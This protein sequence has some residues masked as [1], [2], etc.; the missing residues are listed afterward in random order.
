MLASA[1]SGSIA[2]GQERGRGRVDP[3]SAFEAEQPHVGPARHRHRRD[4][5]RLQVSRW[6]RRCSRCAAARVASPSAGNG[7]LPSAIGMSTVGSTGTSVVAGAS[8]DDGS[9]ASGTAGGTVIAAASVA[10]GADGRCR[11]ATVQSSIACVPEA[12]EHAAINA[13]AASHS[14]RAL[15]RLMIGDST[16]V[17]GRCPGNRM[18]PRRQSLRSRRLRA[19]TTARPAHRRRRPCSMSSQRNSSH[20]VSTASTSAPVQAAYGSSAICDVGRADPAS[21]R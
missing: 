1:V 21:A 13:G 19:S 6:D 17:S 8:V 18:R 12:L 10:A 9:G 15:A 11:Y 14:E 20:S 7:L 5:P 3:D 4:Q 16:A 2:P